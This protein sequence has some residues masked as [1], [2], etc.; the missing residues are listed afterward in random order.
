LGSFFE[1]QAPGRCRR[2]SAESEAARLAA[3]VTCVHESSNYTL[4]SA[5][6]GSLGELPRELEPGCLADLV[7]SSLG[8]TTEDELAVLGELDT[9][10]RLRL[11]ARLL[12]KTKELSEVRK[13][14]D[15]E[16]RKGIGKGQREALLREQLRAIQRELCDD[17]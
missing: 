10:E 12:G 6:G 7:A 4:A 3:K 1:A 16:V 14:I 15:A 5:G 2:A 17:T 13:Q 11:V 8:L 9:T